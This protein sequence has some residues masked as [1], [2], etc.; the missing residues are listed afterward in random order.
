MMVTV[1]PPSSPATT[2]NENSKDYTVITLPKTASEPERLAALGV[3]LD[4]YEWVTNRQM[5]AP[6]QTH[7]SRSIAKP[8][9]NTMASNLLGQ[10]PNPVM[11]THIVTTRCNYSCG[12]CSFADT[13]NSVSNEMSLEEI[14]KTYATLGDMMNVIVYS[15][16]E[17][18]LHKNLPEII[19]AAYRL[20]PVKS[21]YIISN[22]WKP[23]VLFQ[24]THRIKQSCPDLHLTWSLSIEG[25]KEINNK[26]RHTQSKTWDAWQ[27][28]VD[29]MSGIKKMREHFGY[30]ELDVQLCTVCSPDN[31]HAMPDWYVMVRDVLQPDKWNLN[32]M[33]KSVQMTSHEMGSWAARRESGAMEPFEQMYFQITEQVRRDVIS[34]Q[35][36]FLYHTGSPMDGALKSAVDLISQEDNRRIMQGNAPVISCKA[37]S[38][39]AYIGSDGQISGCEEFANN[40]HDNKSFGCLREA[41]YDFQALWRS[42]KANE[43]RAQV[44]KA[45]ECYGCTLE[46]QKNYPSVLVSFRHLWDATALAKQIR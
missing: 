40:P 8:I 27:N 28:T 30:T 24:I 7:W 5:F 38:S 12:F 17:T 37:A 34:G 16:G 31:A 13:L 9:L 20:T 1:L 10:V 44:G 39:G 6:I 42:A 18:T 19:E 26:A 2:P 14:E 41:N 32:L 29:T 36:K 22:A 21:V 11:M 33:R 15:G 45:P 46:S 43:Y 35:L 3:N 25:P 23:D 4:Q